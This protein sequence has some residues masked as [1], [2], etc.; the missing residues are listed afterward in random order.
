MSPARKKPAASTEPASTAAAEAGQATEATEATRAT[1]ETT[2][3][4][5]GPAT[6]AGAPTETCPWCSAKVS[7]TAATCP[8]CGASLREAADGEILG[9]TQID[10]AAVSRAARIKPGRLATWLGADSADDTPVLGGNVEPPSKEVREEMLRL[11]LAAIDAEIEA[12]RQAAEA[13]KLVPDDLVDG[14]A[15][16]TKPS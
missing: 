16:D 12:K 10:P 6:D 13:Q 2:S 7:A 9:V 3:T 5:A 14:D 1:E 15:P 8:S 11:E 4:Q